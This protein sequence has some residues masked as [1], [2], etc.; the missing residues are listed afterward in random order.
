VLLLV[1]GGVGCWEQWSEAWF[2]QMKWQKAVQAFE[3][4]RFEDHT[5][6]FTPPEGTVPIDPA[7]PR[8]GRLDL[9]AAAELENPI[10]ATFKS[11]ARGQELY[12]TYCQVCHGVT[13]M[14]DGPVSIAGEKQGPFIG[15]WPLGTATGQS[16]GYIYNLIRIGNGGQAGYQMPSYARIPDEDRWHIVNYV[17]YLQQGGQP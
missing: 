16:D 12:A 10:P 2:P 8:V 6:G 1:S 3:R 14:G 11:V 15:V 7:P 17:R 5:Q 13:G 4:V 9:A